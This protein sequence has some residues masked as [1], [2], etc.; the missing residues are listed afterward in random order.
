MPILR[1]AVR[2]FGLRRV[3]ELFWRES[4]AANPDEK[5][6]K[7]G[8]ERSVEARARLASANRHTNR[9]A[10]LRPHHLVTDSACIRTVKAFRGVNLLPTKFHSEW[11]RGNSY[12][13]EVLPASVVVVGSQNLLSVTDTTA[14]YASAHARGCVRRA[15]GLVLTRHSEVEAALRRCPHIPL[16][17]SHTGK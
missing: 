10:W 1:A 12:G 3:M 5:C 4:G 6:G 13:A 14:I 16:G 2:R 9:A 7:S 11:C 15:S 8:S 17:E